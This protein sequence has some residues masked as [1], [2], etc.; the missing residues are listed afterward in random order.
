MPS[1]TFLPPGITTSNVKIST[2][3]DDNQVLTAVDGE[4]AQGEPNL[5]FTGSL[6]TVTGAVTVGSDGSGHDVTFY[7][8]TG[9]DNLTWDASEEQLIITGTDGATSL[10]VADGNVAINDDLEVDGT[11]NLDAVDIDGNVQLDGTFTVGVDDTGHNVKFFGATAGSYMLW[12]QSEDN[13][14][15]PASGVVVGD[16]AQRTI[17]NQVSEFQILGTTG[18]DSTLTIGRW[19]A[20]AGGPNLHFFKSRASSI[21]TLHADSRVDTAGDA[22]GNITFALDDGSTSGEAAAYNHYAARISA[23]LDAA[24]SGANAAPGRLVFYTTNTGVT[25]S[26]A[27][28]IDSSGKVTVSG[29][30]EATAGAIFNEGS[31]DVDFRIESNGNANMFVVDGGTD[32]VGIG[33]VPNINDLVTLGGTHT[34]YSN[35]HGLRIEPTLTAIA[36]NNAA[37]VSVAGT[38]TR[39]GSGDVHQNFWGTSFSAPTVNGTIN[40]TDTATVIIQGAMTAGTGENYALYVD[41]GVSRFDGQIDIGGGGTLDYYHTRI[42]PTWTSG[43]ADSVAATL[44]LA[45]VTTMHSGDTS[46]GAHFATGVG[47]GAGI[48][49]AGNVALITSAY[50]GEPNITV[51]SGAVT[52]SATVYIQG[53]AD[54]SSSD[55]ALLVD[56]GTT[57]I[58]GVTYHYDGVQLG[59]SGTNTGEDFLAYGD[60]SGNWLFWDASDN[61]LEVG[62]RAQVKDTTANTG[63]TFEVTRDLASGSTNSAMVRFNQDNASDDQAAVYID[64]DGSGAGLQLDFAGSYAGFSPGPILY[65]GDTANANMTTGLTINQ[66]GADDQIL[67]FKS[68]D[69]IHGALGIGGTTTE[70]DDYAVF[71][72][73]TAGTDGGGLEITAIAEDHSS[74]SEVFQVWALGGQANTSQTVTGTGLFDFI[75]IEHDGSNARAAVTA[76]GNVFS[77]RAYMDDGGG[78]GFHTRFLVDEDGDLFADGTLSAYDT[79]EDAHLVRALDIARGSKDVIKNEWDNFLKYGEEKLVELGILGDTVENGGLVNVTGL[80]RLHNGA[81]WQGYTRQMELQE[82]VHELETRLLALEGGS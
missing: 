52:T 8:D 28:R 57:R 27:M 24:T 63:H 33:A 64:Q 75:A 54:E 60:T 44:V 41:A 1:G 51:G 65:V 26:E 66:G 29:A 58:D 6:L 79:F 15:I 37:V 18:T 76:G 49:T 21:G 16:T 11:T 14:I 45:P 40:V 73:H 78:V 59:Y 13:L 82:R 56:A 3:G 46:W 47:V 70:T 19:S 30:F 74:N 2:G 4:T 39:A 68:S 17:V 38:L 31:S 71:S 34:G 9:G 80:Q 61:R 42:R 10:N 55:F 53:A 12:D 20:S 36:G 72:K 67:A 77:V 25:E 50:F 62:G 23:Q 81:I 22:L 32:A 5:T 48:T 43:G 69:V 35:T 7:S